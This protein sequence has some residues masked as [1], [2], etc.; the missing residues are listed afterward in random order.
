MDE[1]ARIMNMEGVRPLE[2]KREKMRRRTQ[3]LS[4]A[5]IRDIAAPPQLAPGSHAWVT[6]PS[7]RIALETA[8]ERLATEIRD[9][10]QGWATGLRQDGTT[11]TLPASSGAVSLLGTAGAGRPLIL[12]LE[13]SRDD[14]YTWPDH[15]IFGLA[16]RKTFHEAL[17]Q[18]SL[19]PRTQFGKP[20]AGACAYPSTANSPHE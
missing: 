9:G 14:G 13:R 16:S 17:A 1:V 2:H 12:F 4:A 8:L 15:H 19:D 20:I 5:P 11:V 3:Q 6:G 18:L 7:A 10:R